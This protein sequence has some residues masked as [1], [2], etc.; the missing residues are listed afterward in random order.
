MSSAR[1]R[2]AAVSGVMLVAGFGLG[3]L[4]HDQLAPPER[5]GRVGRGSGGSGG[6]HPP[7]DPYD[8]AWTALVT[9]PTQRRVVSDDLP[10]VL[11]LVADDVGIDM[12]SGYDAHP[13][14]PPTPRIDALADQGVRFR[15]AITA[16]LCSP[17]RAML[18]TGRYPYR[19][20]VGSAIAPKPGWDLPTTE[21]TLAR[22]L[23]EGS[24][25]AYET[26]AIGKWHLA[27][28]DHGGWDHPRKMGFDHH[29]GTM[30]NLMGYLP[31]G[32]PQT[33]TRWQ[34]VV[35]G[36]P[37]VAEGYL[38]SATVDD[39][40]TAIHG[41]LG[42]WFVY[43]GFHAA[44][45]PMHRPPD[46]LLSHPVPAN[47]TEPVLYRAMVEALDTEIGRL[48]DGIPPDV[49][50]RTWVVFL[51]DNGSAPSAVLPP[52]PRTAAKATLTQGGV[53]VPFVVSGPG[54][55]QPGRDSDALINS[56]DLVAT[57][58]EL[59]GLDEPR[60]NDAVSFLPVLRD[61]T[62]AAPR[63]VAYAERFPNGLDAWSWHEAMVQDAQYK[64]VVHNGAEVG[65]YDVVKDPFERDNLFGPRMSAGE[66]QAARRLK[67]ALPPAALVERYGDPTEDRDGG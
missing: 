19:Y 10:N 17:S 29:I 48:L 21:R 51:G 13:L 53:R 49:R 64:L 62:V 24:G 52:W 27:T 60:P 6:D 23:E 55:G 1:V 4:A 35:D 33:Y 18:L 12:I 26:Y 25:G 54:V 41:A 44:H 59:V 2:L 9:Q 34:R 20:G 30:G 5:P 32:T 43:V 58:I 63:P 40:L 66:K 14:A 45:F 15:N 38:T 31:D 22:M 36:Q 16:P 8:P 67:R 56:T 50:A 57:V 42:P 61:P 47:A 37:S 46:A 65:L 3:W 28:P 7:I 39:A 11:V